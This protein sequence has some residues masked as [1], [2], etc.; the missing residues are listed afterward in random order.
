MPVALAPAV[1]NPELLFD[2]ISDTFVYALVVT[3][4]A[5]LFGYWLAS[6]RLNGMHKECLWDNKWVWMGC[7]ATSSL[8]L[9]LAVWLVQW[10]SPVWVPSDG[11]SGPGSLAVFAIV[12][13]LVVTLSQL[14]LSAQFVALRRAVRDLTPDLD[15]EWL[16]RLSAA[17][18]V[19]T[20]AWALLAIACLLLP[21]LFFVRPDWVAQT[22]FAVTAVVVSG[23]VAALVGASAKPAVSFVKLKAGNHRKLFVNVILAISTVIFVAALLMSLSRIE[24]LIAKWIESFLNLVPYLNL[25]SYLNL[26]FAHITL[27]IAAAGLVWFGS[28]NINVNRFSLHGLYRNRLTRAF[29]GAGHTRRKP[30]PFTGFDPCD[31]VRICK[32]AAGIDGRSVLFP[33]VNVAL[34]L[35]RGDRLAWQERKAEPFVITP[36]GC[37]SAMLNCSAAGE[38]GTPPDGAYCR[39]DSYG[40][41][42]PDTALSGTGIS[43]AT[44]MTI[45]GAAAS[46]SMG[47]HSSP[48]TSF[49]MTLFNVRLGAWLANPLCAA[50]RHLQRSGPSFALRPL[51]R[52][53]LGLTNDKGTDIHLSDGGHFENLGVYE[54]VRRRCRFIVV[55]D[56]SCDPDCHF[57]DL[58]NA[59]R[60]AFIDQNIRIDIQPKNIFARTKLGENPAA[61]ALGTIHYPERPDAPGYLLYI[62]P[63]YFPPA[64]ADL[65]AYAEANALFP[66]E[67][68]SDQWYSESQFESYRKLGEFLVE[69]LGSKSVYVSIAEFFAE[70]DERIQPRGDDGSLETAISPVLTSEQWL[71]KY[72]KCD[73]E[74]DLPDKPDRPLHRCSVRGAAFGQITVWD[75]DPN[76]MDNATW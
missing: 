40:G 14:V 1:I 30:D 61:Y 5:K 60:K 4:L 12:G 57:E 69:Q 20:L 3:F 15:R 72:G 32:L 21:H 38:V 6:R 11:T 28:R 52:E 76:R 50:S 46:P 23:P 45:S 59:V 47:Y 41:I 31:N 73:K 33:V 25:V 39:S 43:L 22:V 17:K 19:P 48:T 68:T 10:I 9:A 49:L 75:D 7:S 51:L 58:G 66:H 13:P 24:F 63:S 70:L 53:M 37:G 35:V 26:V 65:R 64:P 29:L 36:I 8:A 62:K 18:I 67:S 44:A 27:A 74:S 71:E 54:M 42:E 16:A 2:G 34:N 56:A 55:S